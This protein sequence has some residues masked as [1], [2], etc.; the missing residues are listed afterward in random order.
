M[1][2]ACCHRPQ[3]DDAT[4]VNCGEASW[5]ADDNEAAPPTPKT[6][7][8]SKKTIAAEDAADDNEGN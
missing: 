4:C 5:T 6:T 1:K 8:R 2:C 3:G 7:R